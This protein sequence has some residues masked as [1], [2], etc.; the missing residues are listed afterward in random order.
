[1]DNLRRTYER[2]KLEREQLLD[3]PMAQFQLWF[4]EASEATHPEWL[5]INAMTLSTTD[6]H[7]HVSSRIVLLKAVD[8]RGFTFFTNY[9]SAKGLQLAINPQAALLLYWPHT[10][11]QVRIEGLVEKTDSAISDSYFQSRPRGSQIGAIVSP[12]SQIVDDYHRLES[13]AAEKEQEFANRT[14][15]RPEYWGGYRL[16]PSRL[17]FWQGRPNRLHDRFAYQRQ[18][19]SETW[20]IHRVAP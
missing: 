18:A 2:H 13:M 4:S 16:I 19:D 9:N 15:P 11:R 20:S 8:E 17:E 3:D 5:E 7:G 14:L 6:L 1:M 10:E 12:Q